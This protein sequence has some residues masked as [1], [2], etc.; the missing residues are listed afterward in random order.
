MNFQ[1]SVRT[2]FTKYA[3]FSGKATR[4]EFWWYVLFI[5]LVSFIL[6]FVSPLLGG[7]FSLATLIPSIAVTTRR[8]HDTNRS[9][10]WQLIGLVPIVGFIVLLV[11]LTQESKGE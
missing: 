7:I 8:L 5:F 11:F 6:A 3:D 9:G 1:E 10:W 4:P 2:C